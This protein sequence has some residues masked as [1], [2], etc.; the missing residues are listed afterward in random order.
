MDYRSILRVLKGDKPGHEFHGNQ[1]GG[2]NGGFAALKTTEIDHVIESNSFW[3]DKGSQNRGIAVVQLKDGSRAV[4]KTCSEADANAEVLAAQVGKVLGSP[5]RD[6]QL[7]PGSVNEVMSPLIEGQTVVEKGAAYSDTP[8]DPR[9]HFL[10][11]VIG[12][13]DRN[14]GNIIISPD[15]KQQIGI[16]QSSA[17]GVDEM[18][19]RIPDFT[20]MGSPSKDQIMSWTDGLQSLQPNFA[21]SGYAES[22]S[23]MMDNWKMGATN[24]MAANGML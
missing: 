12:N 13:W 3:G 18:D 5:I 10:D 8:T 1:W 17:F 19:S 9:I 21:S 15:G 2:G 14:P 16:D 7:V 23:K 22:F 11:D 6:A 24:Y 20:E 4:V